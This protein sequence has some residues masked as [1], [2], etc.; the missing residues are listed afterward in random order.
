[1]TDRVP[2]ELW[3]EVRDCTGDRD[4]NHPHGK[5]LQK[6]KMAFWGG[7]T[8]SCEVEEAGMQTSTWSYDVISTPCGAT[9]VGLCSRG[10]WGPAVPWPQGDC[11]SASPWMWAAWSTWEP[12]L[13]GPLGTSRVNGKHPSPRALHVHLLL[14]SAFPRVLCPSLASSGAQSNCWA[15]RGESGVG[16]GLFPRKEEL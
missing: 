6:S 9:C 2:D 11:T 7:L 3:T 12:E 13:E 4:Q 10:R 15:I 5:E 1:M 16:C 8:N 14:T